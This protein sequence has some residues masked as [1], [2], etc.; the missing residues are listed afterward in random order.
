MYVFI[1][2]QEYCMYAYINALSNDFITEFT[3]LKQQQGAYSNDDDDGRENVAK[4]GFAS[5]QT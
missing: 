1:T 4:N 5:F 3:D 2:L